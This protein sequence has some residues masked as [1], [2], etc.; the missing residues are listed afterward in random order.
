MKLT[1]QMRN[2]NGKAQH[3]GGCPLCIGM[4]LYVTDLGVSYSSAVFQTHACMQASKQASACQHEFNPR[5][6]G[7]GEVRIPCLV[8]AVLDAHMSLGEVLPP[9]DLHLNALAAVHRTPAPRMSTNHNDRTESF[10]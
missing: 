4:L 7:G 1:A 5:S 6:R 8:V 3:T 10:L 2:W 9:C